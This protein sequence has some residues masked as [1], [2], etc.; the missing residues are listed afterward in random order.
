MGYGRVTSYAPP[1]NFEGDGGTLPWK[2][3]GR[4][5]SI[6]K[7]RP[8]TTWI[9]TMDGSDTS[10]LIVLDGSHHKLVLDR[11]SSENMWWWL[12]MLGCLCMVLGQFVL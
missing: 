4:V 12:L 1:S 7:D 2:P 6:E 10:S 8:P 5:V 3:G 11:K 9:E